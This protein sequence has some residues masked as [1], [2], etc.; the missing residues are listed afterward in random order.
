[1]DLRRRLGEILDAASAG[2]RF[3]I[4][5]DRRPLAVLVSVEDGHRLDASEDERQARRLAALDR[6]E[7]LGA[8]LAEAHP[9][10]VTAV[11]AIRAER[12]RDG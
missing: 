11:E 9:S 3:I 4:E 7:R 12:G 10:D 5:R 1:M 2:E 6:L 8:R